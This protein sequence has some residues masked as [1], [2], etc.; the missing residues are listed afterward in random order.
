MQGSNGEYVYLSNKER[1]EMVEFVRK[2][3]PKEK[4]IIAGSGCEGQLFIIGCIA[5]CVIRY[6][7][8]TFKRQRSDFF[9]LIKKSIIKPASRQ[10]PNQGICGMSGQV[11]YTVFIR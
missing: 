1:V 9:N 6:V 10:G 7:K 5:F 11:A 3:A 2:E 4:L 8:I